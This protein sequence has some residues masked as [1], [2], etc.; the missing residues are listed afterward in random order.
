[1]NTR[2]AVALFISVFLIS[3]SYAKPVVVLDPGH[4]RLYPGAIG[5][6]QKK[7]VVYND[8]LTVILEKQLTQDYEVVLTRDPGKDVK[9]DDTLLK[10]PNLDHFKKSLLMMSAI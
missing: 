5:T 10:D 7:E 9:I 3:I 1:M 8:E 6:C 4:E 2:F